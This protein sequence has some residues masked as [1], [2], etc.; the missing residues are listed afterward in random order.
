MSRATLQGSGTKAYP[1]RNP[2]ALS[3][4]LALTLGDMVSIVQVPFLTPKM[5]EGVMRGSYPRALSKAGTFALLHR[6]P[7]VQPTAARGAQCVWGGRSKEVEW[8]GE[9]S[10]QVCS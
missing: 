5:S 8:G 1:L 3:A 6:T 2:H 7:D 4:P 9:G 10:G